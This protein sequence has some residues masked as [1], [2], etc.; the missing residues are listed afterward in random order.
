MGSIMSQRFRSIAFALVCLSPLLSMLATPIQADEVT[1]NLDTSSLAAGGYFLDYQLA[2]TDS[3][4]GQNTITISNI[5]L[6]GGTFSNEALSGGASGT[7]NNYSMVDTDV[8]NEALVGFQLGSEVQ[9]G[10]TFTNNFSGGGTPDSFTFALLDSNFNSIVSSGLG[11]SVLIN[12]DGG[13]P[14]VQVFAADEAFNSVTPK[15]V[16]PASQV[17]E[18]SAWLLVFTLL[19]LICSSPTA[20][21]TLMARVRR[22]L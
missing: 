5:Q 12:L 2:G 3:V 16:Q 9:F 14:V 6:G 1:I 20:S 4:L 11:A 19:V 7:F 8:F 22:S 17:P 21:R 10:L 13:N 18:P 15:I